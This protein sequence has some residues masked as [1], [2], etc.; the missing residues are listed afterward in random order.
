MKLTLKDFQADTVAELLENF[1]SA[2]AASAKRPQA[3]LLNAP[4]GSGK[5]VMATRLIEALLE[6][7]DENPGDPDLVFLWLTDQPELN[8]QTYDKMLAD[9]S[10]LA[11]E[12][13]VIIDASLDAESLSPSKVYFLNTQKLGSATSFVRTGDDRTFT[14]WQTIAT[15]IERDPQRFV[16]IVDEAHRGTKGLEFA[17][18]ESIVQKFL[19]GSPTEIDAV[20]LGIGISATP[21]RFRDLCIATGRV[22]WA[23]EVD[24]QLVRDSG[25][26]K[27]AVDLYHPDEA[28]PSDVTLLI[29]AVSSWK[30]YRKMWEKY[31]EAEGEPIRPPVL[32]V[33]VENARTGSKQPSKTDLAVVIGTLQKEMRPAE[34]DSGW[35]AH[36]FQDEAELHIA[37]HK[38]RHLAPSAIDADPDVQ[39]VLF[40]TSLNTGWDCPRA[41]TMVSFRSARD[42]TNIAQLVGRMVR[43][44]LARRID[45]NEFLNTVALYLPFYDRRTVEKVVARLTTDPSVV[46]PTEVREGKTVVTLTQAP[47]SEAVLKVLENLPTYTVPRARPIKPIVRLAKLASLLADAGVTED[48][49]KNY[50]RELMQVLLSEYRRL[51]SK[52]KFKKLVNEAS[53]LDIRQRRVSYLGTDTAQTSGKTATGTIRASDSGEAEMSRVRIADQNV[54]DIYAD[55]GR[56]LGEGLHKEYVR[57]RIKAGTT[58][59]DAKLEV[60]ALVTTEGVLD[61]LDEKAQVLTK[62]W[63]DTNKAAFSDLDEKYRQQLREI[64]G[65]TSDPQ[66]TDLVMPLTIEWTRGTRA[67]PKHLYI[68][69]DGKFYED[70]AKSSWERIVLEKELT[71]DDV[72]GW[73]RN[74]DRKPWSLCFSYRQGAKWV[75]VYP[76]FLIFRSTSSGILADIVDPH[77]F[78]DPRAPARAAGLAKYAAD[79]S[80]KYGRIQLIIVDGDKIKAVDLMERKWRD[81]V[82]K[83]STHDH[84]K[85]IFDQV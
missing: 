55:A 39:V 11:A 72:V 27:E 36:A 73:L 48:P 8:K 68:D 53:V 79:H 84:L 44:P 47:E 1:R 26:I 80:D 56:L 51:K 29:E 83:V 69:D 45:S 42:E 30:R 13:L 19:K 28:Q 65:A 32:L 2:Q 25:L 63:I 4:T 12:Q 10:V 46:P 41:E 17:E 60:F 54:E 82:A 7:D 85:D 52:T 23:V 35:I 5:T 77:L 34:D 16:L 58:A 43:A 62:A 78:A 71:R 49:V 33:Q 22:L 70:F 59:R 67:W 50:R 3:V 76:D 6:G 64:E 75:P 38:I 21:D 18:A 37:G 57:A 61:K 40:K 20:P 74:P 14:V 15:T 81:K 9:S 24:P 66:L 31:G